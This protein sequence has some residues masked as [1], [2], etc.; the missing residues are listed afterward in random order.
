MEAI[1]KSSIYNTPEDV[2]I[3]PYNKAHVLLWY[4]LER[5]IWKCHRAD[6]VK[7]KDWYEMMVKEEEEENS[8]SP[9]TSNS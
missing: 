8:M 2:I 5:H 6:K 7:Q 1:R 4:R 3:C 9:A